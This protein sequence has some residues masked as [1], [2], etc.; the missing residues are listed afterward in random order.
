MIDLN[1]R[2]RFENLKRMESLLYAGVPLHSFSD[3]A[4]IWNNSKGLWY[5]KHAYR[6]QFWRNELGDWIVYFPDTPFTCKIGRRLA[7]YILFTASYS[8]IRPRYFKGREESTPIEYYER[9]LPELR[10]AQQHILLDMVNPKS[11]WYIH[12][13]NSKGYTLDHYLSCVENYVYNGYWE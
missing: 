13:A 9:I 7:R 4:S 6:K 8:T 11:I 2:N 5:V 3:S 1:F 12:Q 10:I